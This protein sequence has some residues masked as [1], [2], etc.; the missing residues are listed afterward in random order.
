M[1]AEIYT[2]ST[3]KTYPPILKKEPTDGK[4]KCYISIHH[5]VG[6]WNSNCKVW[7]EEEGFYDYYS[8]G[9]TNTMGDGQKESAISEAMHWGFCEELPVFIS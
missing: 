5:G 3:V 6:G 4:P 7:E 1:I 9:L 8:T 2:G